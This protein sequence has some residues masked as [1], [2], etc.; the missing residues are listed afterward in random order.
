[1]SSLIVLVISS[2]C[3]A[4]DG[5]G[6]ECST[7]ADTCEGDTICIAGACESAFGRLYDIKNVRVQVPTT[8]PNGEAWDVGGGAPDLLVDVLVNGVSVSRSGAVAD[9]FSATFPGPFSVQPVGGGSLAVQVFD[10]DL[11]TNDLA[12]VC[13]AA[14]LT[15]DLLRTRDLGCSSSAGQVTFRIDP[16]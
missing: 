12:Y 7:T 11:T 3:G 9:M 1:M 6:G 4:D 8:D 15:A 16:R 10:E 14:P 13:S 2:A 5:A